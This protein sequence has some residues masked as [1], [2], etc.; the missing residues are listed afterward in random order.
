[1]L[2]HHQRQWHGP[3]GGHTVVLMNINDNQLKEKT[4]QSESALDLGADRTDLDRPVLQLPT[5]LLQRLAFCSAPCVCTVQANNRL[6]MTL[7]RVMHTPLHLPGDPALDKLA[8]AAAACWAP[9]FTRSRSAASSALAASAAALPSVAAAPCASCSRLC[10]LRSASARSYRTVSE[11]FS[12]FSGGQ[13]HNVP[14]AAMIA[15]PQYK[16]CG[17]H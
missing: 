1:M 17:Q 5:E 8:G 6:S 10:Q 7:A 14:A 13:V 12:G 3:L 2:R 16:R 9:C 4:C 15:A 11:P